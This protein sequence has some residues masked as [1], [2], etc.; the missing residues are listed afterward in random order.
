MEVHQVKC[1][2]TW[3]RF[4]SP[5]HQGVRITRND[6]DTRTQYLRVDQ[7]PTRLTIN[8]CD[9]DGDVVGS[10][11]YNYAQVLEYSTQGYVR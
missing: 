7:T 11:N 1:L 6:G 8:F 4:V 5:N 9:R 3:I 10:I 2:E